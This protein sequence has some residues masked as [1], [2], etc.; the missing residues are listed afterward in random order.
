[1]TFFGNL[2]PRFRHISL[3]GL[4][5]A[6]ALPAAALPAGA[7][8]R[9]PVADPD[10]ITERMSRSARE[11]Q[12]DP[13]SERTRENPKA[14]EEWFL[15]QRAFPYD[16][17]PEGARAA[18][19]RQIRTM[20]EKLQQSGKDRSSTLATSHWRE[21]GPFNV[22]GRIRAIALDPVDR[23]TIYIGAASGGVWKTT[24][25]GQNWSTTFDHQSAL[26]MGALAIDPNN[27]NV[28]YAGTG[29]DLN[30]QTTY[31]GDGVFKSTDAGATWS[32][33][34]LTQ[35]GAF[36]KIVVH[37][38]RSGVIYAG[39]ARGQGG[40]YRSTDAGAT[41]TRTFTS[42]VTD[43]T[44]NQSNNDVVILSTA[45]TLYRSTDAGV[46]FT[47]IA[48]GASGISSSSAT[49][50]SVAIAPSDP[51][52]VYAL[53]ARGDAGIGSEDAEI[54][55]STDGGTT[56]T[57]SR[58]F[59]DPWFFF[60]QG[61][62]NN[63][64]AVDPT[65]PDNVLALGIDIYRTSNGGTRWTNMTNC[66]SMGWFVETAHPDQHV[67]VFDPR[68]PKT[69][70][71]G[72]DG[73]LYMSTNGGVNFNRLT[74]TLPVTQF[75][76]IDVDPTNEYRVYGGTQDNGSAG[77]L[78]ASLSQPSQPW[79]TFAQGDGFFTP[80]DKNFPYYI[81]AE[82][83]NGS[84]IMRY[85]SRDGST[86]DISPPAGTDDPGAWSAPLVISPK[87]G[88]TLYSGRIN[89]W[90]SSNR[91]STWSMLSI[92]GRT[93]ISAIGLSPLNASKLAVGKGGSGVYFST[94]GGSTWTQSKGL[95][96][97]FS[98]C[99]HFDP[100]QD[101]RVYATFSGYGARHVYRSDDGG[102]NFVDITGGLPDLPVNTIAVDPMNN[103]HIFVGTDA[104]AFISLDG[105]TVWLPFNDGLPLAPI[106]DLKIQKASRTLYAGTFG[107]SAFA[108]AIADPQGEPIV[109][110]PSGG[111]TVVTPGSLGIR[112]AGFNGPVRV[113]ISHD[114]GK[115][116]DTVSTGLTSSSLDLPMQIEKNDNV[117]VRIEEM[118]TG[119]AASS[120][121]FTLTATANTTAVTSLG[122]KAEALAVRKQD[123]WMSTRGGDSLY[124]SKL[125]LLTVKQGMKLTGVTGHIR[126]L[127]YYAASD[128]IFALTANDN[129]TSPRIFKLDT[130]GKSLGE[131]PVPAGLA[132]SGIE[133][134]PQGLALIT[135]GL[136]GLVVHID[137]VDGTELSRSN[138][139][140]NAVGVL[141]RA[142]TWDGSG[143]VQGVSDAVASTAISSELQRMEVGTTP[144]VSRT[145]RVVKIDGGALVFYGVAFSATGSDNQNK[146]FY[147]SDT[148]GAVYRIMMS[149]PSSVRGVADR[150]A[151]AGMELSQVIPSPMRDHGEARVRL[152]RPDHVSLE[153]W[154]PDGVMAARLLDQ[155]LPSGES[156][157]PFSITNLASGV[158]YLT[159]V[160]STGER[161]TQP[162]CV[163]R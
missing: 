92:P 4:V 38:Q 33:S 124:R 117:I 77:S 43:M 1:M 129:Y 99:L 19:I 98:T 11:A 32:S 41:W 20:Q 100:V 83:Y 18:A 158:Y 120:R 151:V 104:G 122:I 3:P 34:G 115:T 108:V 30:S 24:N 76:S 89:L 9:E 72:S 157:L 97:R 2:F 57:L 40:F 93:T 55:K 37:R 85:D 121:R 137:P 106:T 61:V 134:T 142:L 27:R 16:V 102:A 8:Q 147:A 69:V 54:Y 45:T 154:S 101:N 74:S 75:Y 5:V 46:T 123:L 62:Y 64:I 53:V 36:S 149:D 105:G 59:N 143:L 39:G 28:I 103:Q 141:R 78:N 148:S 159:L 155:E 107:R 127:A 12:E 17:I 119:R 125:P 56:W 79:E 160:A 140:D 81:Y 68:D 91:G 130:T 153:L 15:L 26:A 112:W 35:V 163:I 13:I 109:V 50:I 114:G 82:N 95:P 126:D 80:V 21:L 22:G 63:A 65:N 87:D 94:N 110:Y 132:V 25:G 51:N 96:T 118:T 90:K 31:M 145:T 71:V 133:M 23:N 14:R 113:L 49:R 111:E 138:P 6:L 44:V 116:F 135:P 73:G 29:E 128:I 7:Q 47:R 162:V 86:E 52:R 70:Y 136:L 152:P 10:G 42:D 60:N 67:V 150:G 139:V 48:T 144:H 156:R 131:L 88:S 146:A 84:P 58:D 161:V 66:Y